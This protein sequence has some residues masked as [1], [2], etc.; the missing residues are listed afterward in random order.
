MFISETISSTAINILINGTHFHEISAHED[1]MTYYR[2]LVGI[3]R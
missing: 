2:Q 1:V 3:V